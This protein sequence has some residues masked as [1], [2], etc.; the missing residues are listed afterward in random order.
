MALR[1]PVSE[2]LKGLNLPSL[3]ARMARP[4]GGGTIPGGSDAFPFAVR[5]WPATLRN[6]RRG[7]WRPSM[8]LWP[9]LEDSFP[10]STPQAV[11]C[12][13]RSPLRSAPGRRIQ[14]LV[15][16]RFL[17]ALAVDCRRCL[18]ARPVGVAAARIGLLD[19]LLCCYRH[20]R[21]AGSP[22]G[23]EL[24]MAR[25]MA[26]LMSFKWRCEASVANIARNGSMPMPVSTING[27]SGMSPPR[28]ISSQMLSKFLASFSP[29]RHDL[30][31]YSKSKSRTGTAQTPWCRRFA[32]C[33]TGC[34]IDARPNWQLQVGFV[35]CRN[36]CIA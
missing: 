10:R 8:R 28:R 4:V 19:C 13:G 2:E 9:Y 27:I 26:N 32:T 23:T 6:G 15:T 1:F 30:R 33:S 17:A 16:C 34:T 3:M 11:C 22:W 21:R 12:G 25:L 7:R 18:H 5:M 24:A 29:T 20:R 14:S 35:T 36:K 31:W